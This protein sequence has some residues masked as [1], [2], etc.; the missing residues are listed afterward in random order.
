MERIL[1]KK[2]HYEV[3]LDF[4]RK[5]YSEG[6]PE[7]ILALGKDPTYNEFGQILSS[8][9]TYMNE[10]EL[11]NAVNVMF[12][13]YHMRYHGEKIYYVTP[14]LSIKLA[15]T[16]LSVDS[17]FLKCP[18]RE[19]HV[20]IEPGL[21]HINDVD[22]RKVSINGFYVNF[23]E[24]EGDK[25]FVRIMASS[26]LK[27][28]PKYK[29]NDSNFYFRLELG[30]GKIRPQ[31][32]KYIK[33]NI[34]ASDKSDILKKFDLYKNIDHFEE[35]AFFIFNAL[36]YITS[37]NSNQIVQEP[38]DFKKREKEVKTKKGRLKL[39]KKIGRE[40]LQRVIIIGDSTEDN[41]INEVKKWGGVGAWKLK[42][43]VHVSG[44]WRTQW[45]GSKKDNSQHSKIIWVN[46]YEKGPE[47]AE[48]I[49]SKYFVK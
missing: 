16:S 24:E 8:L 5:Q 34:E 4:L 28:T 35:F 30:P 18:F 37:Q 43:R 39:A 1:I 13:L 41:K 22:G 27:P 7:E 36:L 21:F 32:K 42:N 19:I 48:L 45:Y 2:T 23:R 14:D 47:F 6:F 20:Q 38:Q 9:Y 40:T 3:A 26:L 12:H 15:Q 46:D 31:V 49:K 44:Y 11:L 10:Y 33:E 25:K 29:F 17:Y